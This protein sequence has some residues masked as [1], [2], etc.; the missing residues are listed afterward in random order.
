MPC[1][2]PGAPIPTSWLDTQLQ[3]TA[4]RS[5]LT[6]FPARPRP[7]TRSLT[8]GSCHWKVRQGLWG[9]GS[10]QGQLPGVQTCERSSSYTGRRWLPVWGNIHQ[11]VLCENRWPYI[12]TPESLLSC[13]LRTQTH[14]QLKGGIRGRPGHG[15]STDGRGPGGPQPDSRPGSGQRG[16]SSYLSSHVQLER[17]RSSHTGWQAQPTLRPRRLQG[18]GAQE[19]PSHQ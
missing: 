16:P 12:K 8:L 6:A 2:P 18:L 7:H 4:Q 17:G 15:G 9:E 1:P 11:S 10:S 19:S 5:P 3:S 13:P 14:P